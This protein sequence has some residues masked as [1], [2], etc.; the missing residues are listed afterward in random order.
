M[1]EPFARQPCHLVKCSGLFEEVGS[2]RDDYELLLAAELRE[3]WRFS[4]MTSTSFPPTI[5]SVGA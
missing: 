3:A 4:C 1:L 2:S 5:R